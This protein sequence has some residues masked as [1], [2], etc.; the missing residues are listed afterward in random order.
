MLEQLLKEL[1]LLDGVSGSENA[2]RDWICG[3]IKPFA[4]CKVDPMGNLIAFKKGAASP[5]KTLMLSAHMDEVGLIIHSI[6]EDGYLSFSPVGGIDP[7]VLL[8][9]SVRIGENCVHGVIGASPIHMLTS[10]ERRQSPDFDK[11][12]IEIG[13]KSREDAEKYVSLGDYACFDSDYVTF[14]DGC[15]KGKALD[16]RAG[17]AVLINMIMQ[18][19]PYDMFFAFTVQEE[20]GTR[21]AAAAAFGVRPDY[22]LVVEATTAA[23]IAGVET[24]R[25]VCALH[26]GPAVSF[27]DGR[28]IYDREFYRLAFEIANEQGIPCQ[29][30]AGTS[31]GNDA[32]AIHM[33]REG[34]RTLAISL[35][36]RYLH[37]ASCVIH[38]DDLQHTAELVKALSVNILER[39]CSND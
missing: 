1:S 34:V 28:T 24:E 29:P 37:S 6:D 12:K 27:M 4:E 17:C 23:D 19:L 30:K 21:G 8:G 2:V 33:S 5:G 7:R 14:G 13:A 38:K 11:L 31:G 15:I 3:K 32:G 25:Q 18:S 35:P 10:E 9:R 22:A 16:D 36:C 26:K 20:V 39:E